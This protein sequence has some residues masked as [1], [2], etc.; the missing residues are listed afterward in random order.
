MRLR[1]HV[2]DAKNLRPGGELAFRRGLSPNTVGGLERGEHRHPHPATVRALADALGLTDA[3]RAAL[4]ATV[5]RR[6]DRAKATTSAPPG[7]PAPLTPLVGREQEVAA[8]SALF[9]QG[10]VR[11]VTLTGPGGVGKTALALGVAAALDHDFADGAVFVPL[12]AVREP[13]FVAPAIARVLGVVDSSRRSPIDRLGAL[14]RDRQLL[15]V[16]D[17]LEHL[18]TAAPVATDLLVRCPGL[19]VLATSR[20]PLRLAGEHVMP[21][22]PLAVPD[23]DHLPETDDLTTFAA[24]RLFVERAR[25]S[26]PAFVLTGENAGA[27]AGICHRLDGLPLALELAAARSAVLS[28]ATLLPLLARRLPLLTAGRRDAPA[29]QRTLV[30]AI[31]WSDDL[32]TPADRTLFRRLAVCVGGFTLETAEALATAAGMRASDAVAGITALVDHSLLRHEPG[33]GGVFRY[34]MLETVREF[35]LERLAEANEEAVTRDAH[36]AYFV[37]LDERLEPNRLAPGERFDE[38]L[39][40]I[41]AEHPNCRAALAHLA[42]TG[43][44][45]GVLRLAGALAVFWHHRGYLHEGRQWLERALEHAVNAPLIWRGRA[46]AGLSLILLSQGDP[47]RAAPAAEMARVI[48]DASDDTE[49][50]ASAVHLLGLSELVQGQWDRA[51]A[52][53][54]DALGIERRIGTPGYGAMALA[55]LGGIAHQRG[56][57]ETSAR[58]AEEALAQFRVVGHASGAAMAL[59]T[60]AGLAAERGDDRE[61]HAAYLEALRLWSSIGERW[62]IAWAL[63]GLAALAAAHGQHEHAAILIGAIETRLDESGADLVLF[64]RRP[65]ERA[66]EAA[67]A[68]LG[69][70][71][72]AELR[73]AGRKLSL[74]DAV[75]LAGEVVVPDPAADA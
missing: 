42:A 39:L 6:G 2:V 17:N 66:S 69:E 28:P 41:E 68:A 33:P 58:L 49:L 52:L 13:G 61:A 19:A 32:L 8:V 67:R 30:D 11:L 12:A 15:L 45:A 1:P 71:R 46:L 57:L 47:E 73:A 25:A 59:S 70:E 38:R 7:L 50:L 53:L 27:V 9:Q 22:L 10:G 29:R 14:L 37:A 72:V 74:K 24:I 26:N 54:T 23:P 18:L 55:S 51:E 35:G 3:E 44:A 64:D 36:A 31:A 4:L 40:R 5:P 56:E 20:S 75:D 62:V 43:D 48:S 60:L 63:S 21:V 16:L 34:L 65:L